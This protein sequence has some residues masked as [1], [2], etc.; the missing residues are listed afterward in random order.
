ME[1]RVVRYF[2]AVVR[3][4]SVTAAARTV[5]V[6]QPSL[7]RQLRALETELGV[8]LFSRSP[9]SL[10]LSAAGTRFVPIAQDLV[11]R[12]EEAGA[13]MAAIGRTEDTPLTL[14]APP[15]TVDSLLAPFM[16]TGKAGPVLR[17]AFPVAPDQVFD[18]LLHSSADLGISTSPPPAQ[19][20]TAALGRV[21]VSAQVRPG[22]RW[23][24]AKSIPLAELATEPLLV[25]NRSNA[26]RLV[27]DEAFHRAGLIPSELNETGSPS[28]AQARAAGR[29]EVC[30]V[31]DLV[32]FGL[33]SIPIETADGPLTVPLYAGWRPDHYAR[34]SI[35]ALVEGLREFR[36]A[37]GE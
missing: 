34:P 23:Y 11:R 6:A 19:L 28:V 30:L 9:G 31:T 14:V 4:G 13:V 27:V 35:L 7:S 37:L 25:M 36:G 8:A 29:G 12:A 26:A 2:L 18:W 15:S 21:L 22:H 24:E 10:T 1:L 20:E 5:R 16:A 32:R 17:D 33:R 3:E